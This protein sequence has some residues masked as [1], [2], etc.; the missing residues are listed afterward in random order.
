MNLNL[1]EPNPLK[2]FLFIS[3][4]ITVVWVVLKLVG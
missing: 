2:D 1:N 4:A 3:T